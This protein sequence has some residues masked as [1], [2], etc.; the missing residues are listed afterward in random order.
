MPR[1]SGRIVRKKLADGSVREYRYPPHKTPAKIYELDT[2]GGLIAAY[3]RSP[4]W[5][6][7]ADSTKAG[8]KIYLRYLE[9]DPGTL[10]KAVKRRE[11][12]ALR[13]IIAND[14]GN[15][16]ATMFMRCVSVLFGWAVDREWIDASPVQRIKP[17]PGG[18]LPAWSAEHV[19]LALEHLPK[20]LA[21]AVF[22]AAATGQRRGDLLALR[23]SQFDG[24]ALRF[25]QQKT[26]T[27]M[28]LP[29]PAAACRAIAGWRGDAPSE[30]TILTDNKGRPWLPEYFSA[31]L[32]Y[33]LA[34]VPGIPRG[35]GI[36]GVRKFKAAD[37]AQRGRTV[38]QIAAVTGHRTL[39]MVALYT[40][41]V[42]QER[43]AREALGELPREITTGANEDDK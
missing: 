18:H 6:A 35:F 1:K 25:T 34:K 3:K 22:L 27:E 14:S 9:N 2:V 15:G 4:E 11:L 32:R 37:L 31:A 5:T 23:W 10:V 38:H 8:Y 7:L 19:R 30:A 24:E 29:L 43:L 40:R 33:A 39:S 26:A 36:H 41:S 17:L 13:D 20:Q 21:R 28:V 16:A 42:D 12:L